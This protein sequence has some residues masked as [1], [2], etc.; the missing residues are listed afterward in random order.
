MIAWRAH[1]MVKGCRRFKQG[2]R[3]DGRGGFAREVVRNY[4]GARR[5]A[6]RLDCGRVGHD[7]RRCRLRRL[8][9]GD[10]RAPAGEHAVHYLTYRVEVTSP[11]FDDGETI[12][13]KYTCDGE[14]VSP[15]LSWRLVGGS[16]AAVDVDAALAEVATFALIVEDPDAPSG[17]WTHWIVYDIPAEATGQ[18]ERVSRNARLGNGGTQGSTDFGGLGYDGPCPPSG[19]P[20]RYFFKMFAV[21]RNLEL[22]AGV[23]RAE[24]MEAMEG[25]IL[26][27]GQL[28]GLYGR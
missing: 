1:A 3:K 17:V 22:G 21:A 4:S 20:H 26:Y 13:V 24:L 25:S 19:A 5:T 27:E 9:G 6:A 16:P 2:G 18:H 14:D 15:T 7:N 10:A 11:A 28:I 23:T 12:P 8:P